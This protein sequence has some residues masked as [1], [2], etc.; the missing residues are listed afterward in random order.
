MVQSWFQKLFWNQDCDVVSNLVVEIAIY[1]FDLFH[2]TLMQRLLIINPKNK[3]LIIYFVKPPHISIILHLHRS[4]C[5]FPRIAC[6]GFPLH[7][8]APLLVAVSPSLAL[9]PRTARAAQLPRQPKILGQAGE[10]L[11]AQP[12]FWAEIKAKNNQKFTIVINCGIVWIKDVAN[13]ITTMNKRFWAK[14]LSQAI[15]NILLPRDWED[16]K[17]TGIKLDE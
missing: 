17:N 3:Q 10:S 8:P 11:F 15:Q 1:N 13:F 4:G 7:A 5:C 9:L 6:P 2:Y 14:C 16:S 12:W